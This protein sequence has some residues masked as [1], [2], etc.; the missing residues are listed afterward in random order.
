MLL[1]LVIFRIAIQIS[2]VRFRDRYAPMVS[3]VA[4]SLTEAGSGG[5]DGGDIEWVLEVEERRRAMG[6]VVRNR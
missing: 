4:V 5:E 3:A 1:H 2:D 6:M